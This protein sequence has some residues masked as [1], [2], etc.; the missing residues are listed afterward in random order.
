MLKT[1]ATNDN[2]LVEFEPRGERTKD[3]IVLPGKAQ[4]RMGR[5]GRVLSVGRGAHLRDGLFAAPAGYEAINADDESA[6]YDVREGDRILVLGD[7]VP[8]PELGERVEVIKGVY[9]ILIQPA[10]EAGDEE[11]E[12]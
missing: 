8:V 5:W 7:G 3:G 11:I 6:T 9:V 4:V 1:R 12:A 10:D 2:L